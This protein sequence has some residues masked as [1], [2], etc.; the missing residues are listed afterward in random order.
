MLC[1]YCEE[2][3]KIWQDRF[4]AKN[5]TIEDYREEIDETVGALENERIWLKGCCG[6]EEY[7]SHSQNIANILEYLDWLREEALEK[8]S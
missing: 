5:P 8:A 6:N 2:T 3:L 4:L 1:T 7:R